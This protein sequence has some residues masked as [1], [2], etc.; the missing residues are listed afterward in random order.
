MALHENRP[1][2][3]NLLR[4]NYRWAYTAI[5]AKYET[6]SARL[7]WIY[8]FPRLMI[9]ASF[10]IAFIHSAYIIACWLR[11]GVREP[12]WMAPA[13][14]ASRFAYAAGMAVGGLRW[15]RHRNDPELEFRPSWR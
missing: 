6:G 13:I 14:L 15:L 12:L 3:I 8:R 2:F 1:G 11:A 5:P 9:L 7:A 10:P 4:R